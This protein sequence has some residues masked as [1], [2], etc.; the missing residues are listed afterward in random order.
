[1]KAVGR[2]KVGRPFTKPWRKAAQ[3]I[4]HQSLIFYG[5]E[6]NHCDTVAKI[7]PLTFTPPVMTRR[8]KA[9]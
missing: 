6:F 9:I 3:K 1:V 8:F 4:H 7:M 5:G 2:E